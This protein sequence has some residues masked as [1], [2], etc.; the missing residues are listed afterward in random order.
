MSR[1]FRVVLVWLLFGVFLT[2]FGAVIAWS[3]YPWAFSNP[4][5]TLWE[6]GPA[7]VPNTTATVVAYTAYV[8][9]VTLSNVTDGA[10]TVTLTDNSTN[11]NSGTCAFLQATSIAANTTYV[12]TIPGGRKFPDGVKWSASSASAIVGA[13][14]GTRQ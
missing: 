3:Q 12:V 6:S 2:L 14:R 11:C 7:F 5:R 9:L 13:I 10:V 8:D 4:G 1:N